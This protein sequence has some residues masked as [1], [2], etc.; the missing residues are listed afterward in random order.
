MAWHRRT[1]FFA[2]LSQII[3]DARQQEKHANFELLHIRATEL[4]L[5][6]CRQEQNPYSWIFPNKASYR[7]TAHLLLY[8]T[9]FKINENRE[10]ETA[11]ENSALYL[12][13]SADVTSRI[14]TKTFLGRK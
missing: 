5:L 14:Y 11:R 8:R 4:I 6:H 2:L 10:R 7:I 12:N 13:I 3:W 1:S 9:T